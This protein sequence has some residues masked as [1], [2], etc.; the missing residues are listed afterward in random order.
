MFL[1]M[2][3]RYFSQRYIREGKYP[4]VILLLAEEDLLLPLVFIESNIAQLQG[5]LHSV[6]SY[7]STSAGIGGDLIVI[8]SEEEAAWYQKPEYWLEIFASDDI[9]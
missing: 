3:T 8:F 6:G 9:Y 7:S 1:N 5:N 4:W 2:V